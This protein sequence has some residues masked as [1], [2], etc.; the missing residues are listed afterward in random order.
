VG[1]LND[2]YL[3]RNRPLGEARVLWE[4]GTDG[5]DVRVLRSRLD[6]DSGYLSRLLRALEAAGLVRVTSSASDKR[7]RTAVLTRKGRAERALLDRRS[8]ELAR[9]CLEPLSDAQ[10]ERLVAAMTDVERLLTAALVDIVETDPEER[11]ARWCIAQYFA[12]LD[13]RFP[14]GFDPSA[15]IPAG[16]DELRPPAGVLLV[17]RLHGDPVGCGALKFHGRAPTELKRM[18]VSPDA[19]G[20]GVGRRLLG[21][22]EERA[23]ASGARV[24]RLETNGELAEAIALYRSSGYEEVDAFNDEP[25]AHHWFE[26]RLRARRG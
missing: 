2:R 17:A 11:D 19:R 23:E 3:G 26:K 16:A 4:I 10:R 6:L 1:A 21:A 13:R 5:C 25:Y 8:D 22:L 9:S 20:L 12:E 7:V 15:S 14:G 24:V 18:W